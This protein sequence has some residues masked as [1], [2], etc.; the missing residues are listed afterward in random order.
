MKGRALPARPLAHRIIA[1]RAGL[2]SARGGGGPDRGLRHN[3]HNCQRPSS[4]TPPEA[5]AV[6][7][8]ESHVCSTAPG[9]RGLHPPETVGLSSASKAKLLV[10]R[11]RERRG[12]FQA[13]RPCP[14]SNLLGRASLGVVVTH[15]TEGVLQAQGSP[16][17]SRR[18]HGCGPD[19]P[20]SSSL[21]PARGHHLW[22]ELHPN[23]R[24]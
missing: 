7:P 5:L 14:P 12:G 3:S 4:F 16:P 15:D 2:E 10:G 24:C 18:S 20:F 22:I 11:Q 13:V 17:R 1:G 21:S 9:H 19:L 6:Y 8:I 23:S